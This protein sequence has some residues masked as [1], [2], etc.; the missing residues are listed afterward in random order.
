MGWP[1]PGV[2]TVTFKGVTFEVTAANYTRS[3]CTCTSPPSQAPSEIIIR[4][5]FPSIP[6]SVQRFLNSPTKRGYPGKKYESECSVSAIVFRN[7]VRL[8][9]PGGKRK[10][11]VHL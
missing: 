3:P 10:V 11:W 5:S 2:A 8:L 9:E 6:S 1:A 4:C 7:T